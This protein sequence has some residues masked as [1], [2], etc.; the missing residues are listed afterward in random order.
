MDKPTAAKQKSDFDKKQDEAFAEINQI[1]GTN[2]RLARKEMRLTTEA[3]SKFVNMST[4][5]VG[6]IERGERTPSFQSLYRICTFF[7]RSIDSMLIPPHTAG[8]PPAE[9]KNQL[10]RR[11]EVIANMIKTFDQRGL[12]YII[13]SIKSLK[14]LGGFDQID[15]N[16]EDEA[17]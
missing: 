9:A 6:L 2:L 11:R 16:S 8:Q 17:V 13:N 5:Y 4:A 12:D 1:F 15:D 10:T 7:G 3:L 14:A